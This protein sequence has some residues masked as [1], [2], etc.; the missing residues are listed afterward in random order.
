MPRQILTNHWRH[1][2]VSRRRS[3]RTVACRP[4]TSK[5]G[6]PPACSWTGSWFSTT[7]GYRTSTSQRVSSTAPACSTRWS[8]P[9]SR[10]WSRAGRSRVSSASRS[11]ACTVTRERS[12]AR[13]GGSAVRRSA[14]C[15]T[16]V[17]R[18]TDWGSAARGIPKRTPTSTSPSTWLSTACTWS[19]VWTTLTTWPRRVTTS[20]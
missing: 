9:R 16:S 20:T 11:T 19:T 14:S 6:C 2:S 3:G 15:R 18:S 17:A 12:T 4:G 1:G 10:S 13:A 5:T 8:T 7:G